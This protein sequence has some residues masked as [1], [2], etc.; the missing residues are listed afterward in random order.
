MEPGKDAPPIRRRRMQRRGLFPMSIG[1][2]GPC[3]REGEGRGEDCRA[4]GHPANGVAEPAGRLAPLYSVRLT[5]HGHGGCTVQLYMV[6][7]G[8]TAH[9]TARVQ[10]PT[11]GTVQLYTVRHGT[12]AHGTAQVQL[13]MTWHGTATHGTGATAQVQ[14]HMT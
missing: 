4:R 3:R 11:H 8:T 14:L 13:H 6:R 7:H 1:G 2:D 12:T 5:R 10:T 9:G